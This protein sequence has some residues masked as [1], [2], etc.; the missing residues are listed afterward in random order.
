MALITQSE[1]EY[2]EGEQLFTG[3]GS[4]TTFTLTFTSIFR[5]L[6]LH[7]VPSLVVRT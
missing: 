7:L 1:R 3:D 2:Y 4:D 5:R 6:R